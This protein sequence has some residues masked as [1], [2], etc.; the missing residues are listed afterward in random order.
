MGGTKTSVGC[1]NIARRRQRP[2]KRLLYNAL[3]VLG[4]AL[5][6]YYS[7]PSYDQAN[8]QAALTTR[9]DRG[10]ARR[11]LLFVAGVV[12]LLVVLVQLFVH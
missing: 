2:V 8:A 9:R 7:P 11:L 5:G 12:A 6:G 10:R 3:R 4:V 1:V